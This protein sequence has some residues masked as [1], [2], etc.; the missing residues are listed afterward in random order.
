[1]QI[2]LRKF[3]VQRIYFLQV[4]LQQKDTY[5]NHI[6]RNT[7]RYLSSWPEPGHTFF[8]RYMTKHH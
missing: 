4:N 7:F 1:M 3:A 2:Q 6:G 8:V 5:N